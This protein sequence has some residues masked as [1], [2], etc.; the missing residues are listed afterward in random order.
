MENLQ[1]ISKITIVPSVF[2][3]TPY[4]NMS[5][6]YVHIPTDEVITDMQKLGWVVTE[7]KEVKARKKKGY[8]KHIVKFY[9]PDLLIKGENGDDSFP[10]ILM[11]N[12]HDGSTA[13]QFR[14]GLYR[15]VC[16]NGLVIADAEFGKLSI[17]HMG[18]TFEKLQNLIFELVE[19]IP[20]LVNKIQTFKDCQLTDEQM[21]K[22]ALDASTKRFGDKYKVRPEDLLVSTR[23]ADEGHSLWTVFNRVQEKLMNGGFNTINPKTNKGRASR[24]VKSFA[25]NIKLNEDLWQLAEA[26]V[27]K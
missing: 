4:M 15:I 19:K 8:Q 22:F 9:H 24:S 12:S 2:T 7:S 10:E 25:K 16:S 3:K 13:F 14:V 11:I 27:C 21:M 23:T 1:E 18:Y 20:S 6:K 26:Y 5:K 17:R